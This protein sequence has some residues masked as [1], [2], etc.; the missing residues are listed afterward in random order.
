MCGRTKEVYAVAFTLVLH[1]LKFLLTKLSILVA[2][3][4]AV[5]I[6]VLHDIE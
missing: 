2:F 4:A 6:C 5:L 3:P 1:L